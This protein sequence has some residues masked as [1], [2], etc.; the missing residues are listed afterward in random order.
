VPDAPEANQRAAASAERRRP[1]SSADNPL[2]R[3]V[4]RVPAR[5]HT[6]LLVAFVGT[7]VLV[8][9]IGLLGLRLLGQSNDRVAGLGALQE[10]AFAYGK[11]QSDA[12]N[13]RVLLAEDVAGDFYK[14]NNPAFELPRHDATSVHQAAASALAR[15]GPATSVVALGFVPPPED[16]RVLGRIRAKTRQLSTVVREIVALDTRGASSVRQIRLHHAAEQLAID[17]NQLASELANA[18]TAK[19]AALIAQNASSYASSR[20]LFIGVAAG[21]IVLALLLGFVLS[22]SLI[23]PIQRIDSRLAAIASGDF[24]GHVEVPNRD[25]LG[26]LGA[27]V[28]RMN[29]ELR[30]LYRELETTSQHKSEFLANMSHELRTPLNAIIGFSQ[31]LRERMFGEVNEKQAEYLEDIL[32]SGNHLLALINDVLDL[33]KVEA[34]QIELEA[35]PFSLRDALERGVVMVRERAAKDGVAVTVTSDTAVNVVEGDERR[36]RQVIFNL[37]SNAVKFTPAGGAVQVSAAHVDGEVRVSVADTGPGIAPEDHERIFE[38]FQQT[39]AGIEQREG[40]GLGLALSKRLV[41]LHGGQIWVDS[42]PGRGS[43]FV[44]TLPARSS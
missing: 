4:G 22:W 32:S 1:L 6:K 42:E 28:N 21:A 38:E 34:G 33:S 19:T 17:L 29:D 14:L 40:T 41:E 3:A 35:A 43:T 9:V 15:I 12:L 18:T 30:R 20:N 8:V 2:V 24:S 37:L 26:A 39:E 10:R 5:V 11:L 7:A 27:N 36:I 44:F 13:I 16:A 25:E 31:V 23:G